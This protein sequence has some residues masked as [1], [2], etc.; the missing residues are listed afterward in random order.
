MTKPSF[1]IEV[2]MFVT[3]HG[4]GLCHSRTELKLVFLFYNI[5]VEKVSLH[6]QT[7]E[8]L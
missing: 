4:K 7:N 2:V 3:Y 5:L 1:N 6:T 8:V